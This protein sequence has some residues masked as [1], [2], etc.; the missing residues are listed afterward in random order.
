[1]RRLMKLLALAPAIAALAGAPALAQMAA[2]ADNPG[3]HT[4][5]KNG[6][7]AV[8]GPVQKVNP[9]SKTIEV[10]GLIGRTTLQV[11]AGTLIRSPQGRLASLTDIEEG[12]KVRVSFETRDGLNI[13]KT[14]EMLPMAA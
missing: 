11:T 9:E 3:V 10:G 5:T 13:A 14:I 8:E 6:E 1:M 12:A 2:P 4:P 7:K